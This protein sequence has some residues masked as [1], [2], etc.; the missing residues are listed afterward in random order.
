M[1]KEHFSGQTGRFHCLMEL[2][3]D[4]FHIGAT[5]V[6]NPESKAIQVKYSIVTVGRNYTVILLPLHK[7]V[8]MLFLRTL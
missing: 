2:E 4:A 1:G 3:W 8:Y 6:S 5:H 7:D